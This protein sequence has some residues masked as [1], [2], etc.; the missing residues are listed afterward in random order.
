MV[1]QV[2][3]RDDKQFHVELSVILR[4]YCTRRY[5]LPAAAGQIKAELL[6]AMRGPAGE[7]VTARFGELWRIC[8]LAEFA[9]YR[10]EPQSAH[11]TARVA[12]ELIGE[13]AGKEFRVS[14][15]ESPILDS[16]NSPRHPEL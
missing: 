1:A 10:F 6:G 8:E 4:D 2:A 7:A 15:G 5:G 12:I 14:S 3:A 11:Q 13:Q 16:I 9:R